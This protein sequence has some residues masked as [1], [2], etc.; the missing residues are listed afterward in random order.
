MDDASHASALPIQFSNSFPLVM[1]GHLDEGSTAARS[2]VITGTRPV[3]TIE[4]GEA[5]RNKCGYEGK[6]VSDEISS[7]H[8]KHVT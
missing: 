5:A 8:A 4:R 3:M 2:I 1:V 6:R 7:E